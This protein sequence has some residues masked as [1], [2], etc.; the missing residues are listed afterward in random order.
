MKISRLVQHESRYTEYCEAMCNIPRLP[1]TQPQEK[2][3]AY[4]L[5]NKPWEIVG[6]DII[7]INKET[8]LCI[9]DYCRK[10]PIV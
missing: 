2:I 9:V 6:E 7:L 4:E 10:F 5:L 8:L 1:D 3:N